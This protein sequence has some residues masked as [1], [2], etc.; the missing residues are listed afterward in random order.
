MARTG[1]ADQFTAVPESIC[2]YSLQRLGENDFFQISTVLESTNPYFCYSFFDMDLPDQIF[3]I[4]PFGRRMVTTVA[5]R[6]F[7]GT[8][9][10]ENA[11]IQAPGHSRFL[12]WQIRFQDYVHA[13]PFS[14]TTVRFLE[15]PIPS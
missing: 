6:D 3:H 8:M 13:S 12:V 15:Y 4:F 9:N 10:D 7:A 2:V 5:V 1:Y 14:Y 11:I